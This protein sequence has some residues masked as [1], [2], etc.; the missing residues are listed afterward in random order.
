MRNI[1]RKQYVD[2]S[3]ASCLWRLHVKLR[4]SARAFVIVN[5][6]SLPA[7]LALFLLKASDSIVSNKSPLFTHSWRDLIST[8]AA[9]SRGGL[10][11]T[12]KWSGSMATH[13]K[14][15]TRTFVYLT[16]G[17]WIICNLLPP[18]VPIL[19]AILQESVI[20]QECNYYK[21]PTHE[22]PITRSDSCS[23]L[24]VRRSPH[25]ACPEVIRVSVYWQRPLVMLHICLFNRLR[26]TFIFFLSFSFSLRGRNMMGEKQMYGAVGS[27]S[28]LYWWWVLASSF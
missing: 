10:F 16:V 14:G 5:L 6:D 27:F 1:T 7:I 2:I 21:A 8:A 11:K 3:I 15:I 13:N 18:A 28:L 25:Y 20:L 19:P 23:P 24:C 26:L 12:D 22:R 9:H 4:V 17:L